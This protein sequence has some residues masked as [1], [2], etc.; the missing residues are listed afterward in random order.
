MYNHSRMEKSGLLQLK[1]GT[2]VRGIATA[3]GGSPVT[4]TDG[5]V[6]AIMEAF[7]FRLARKTGKR[8]LKIA[9]GRDVRISGGRIAEACLRAICESGCDAVD[10]GVCSTPSMFMLL[11]R[12]GAD[13]DASVMVTASHLPFDRNGL[14][15]F[16][17]EGGLDGGEITEILRLAEEGARLEGGKTGSVFH[18]PFLDEYCR[19]LVAFVREKCGCE[20]PLAGKKI[21]VDAG[22]GA[23]GFF[24]G[25]VLQPLGADTAGS[26]FLEPD[27]RF[28]NHIPN[29][30]DKQ[31]IACLCAAVKREKADLGVIFDTDVDR[32]GAVD[33]NGEEINRSRLI[34]L[35]AAVL[36]KD[37]KG[38]IVTDSVTSGG[39]T[40]FIESL[41]GKHVR[42]KRGYK[43]VIDE[44]VRRNAAGE[45]CP[46]AIETSGHA[47]FR[48]NYFLDDGAYLVTR[49]LILLAGQTEKGQPL[50]GLIASLP[51]PAEEDEV[52]LGFNGR[53][54]DFRSEGAQ[55]IEELAQRAKHSPDMTL[56]PDN[57]EG[58]KVIFGK[59]HGDGWF[60]VRM[61]VHDPVMPVN[62]ESNTAGGDRI[63]AARLLGLLE[64]YP[65]LDTENLVRFTKGT[66]GA[67]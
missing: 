55:V 65:F 31:A 1:S 3:D 6:T 33:A 12:E 52:R 58:V 57:Y 11:K 64:K 44:A 15:F 56:A 35:M 8:R 2:D 16:T 22:N 45:N 23:G 29:P 19:N 40:P 28:P 34:A 61:S 9:L 30:E 50:T 66:L 36:L 62:F 54:A 53:S 46:L 7:L 51:R 38:T 4:L 13:C 5:A 42:F 21:I 60:L 37:G 48:D 59:E 24:V 43:N 10:T 14:K 41:G 49:I 27:G 17:P 32:A 63:I 39:L 26:M 18:A 25:K 47:A 20:R 67:R